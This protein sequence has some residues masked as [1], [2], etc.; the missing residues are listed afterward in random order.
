MIVNASQSRF[1][2]M[3][4]PL[5]W[6]SAQLLVTCVAVY[7]LALRYTQKMCE[8]RS[9]FINAGRVVSAG[10][11]RGWV[12]PPAIEPF[13]SERRGRGGAPYTFL[14]SYGEYAFM[15][16]PNY[17]LCGSAM[18]QL[19]CDCGEEGRGGGCSVDARLGAGGFLI[20]DEDYMSDPSSSGASRGVEPTKPCQNIMN[21]CVLDGFACGDYFDHDDGC[22]ALP[23]GDPVGNRPVSEVANYTA[24][25]WALVGRCD[26]RELC[27]G[28]TGVQYLVGRALSP[29]GYAAARVL[30]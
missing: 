2:R 12:P 6:I 25:E 22:P 16:K 15:T 23:L 28:L 27:S 21:D 17:R 29:S 30:C 13:V 26:A 18:P 19:R 8:P 10:T 9:E 11:R 24:K 4:Y 20:R 1:K 5:L 7:F 3:Q 14:S